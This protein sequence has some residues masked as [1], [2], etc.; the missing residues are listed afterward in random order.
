VSEV[1]VPG[2]G[3]FGSAAGLG[4]VS[5]AWTHR[6]NGRTLLTTAGKLPTGDASRLLGSGAVDVAAGLTYRTVLPRGWT[7]YGQAGVVGQGTATY[8]PSS[9]GLVDQW[10]MAFVG[11]AN[12]RDAWTIQWQ[13]E[14]SATV[15]GI[16]GSDSPHRTAS[17]GYER[18]LSSTTYLQAFFMEDGD[19]LN[20]RIPEI[21]NIAPDFTIGLRYGIRR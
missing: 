10:S 1:V 9:R 15:T 3:R 11:R 2:A 13:S 17:L 6:L 21:V 18:H 16:A 8:L 14:S 12:S 19:W 7:F 5:A 20:F 4:D